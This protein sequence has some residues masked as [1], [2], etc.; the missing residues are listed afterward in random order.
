MKRRLFAVAFPALALAL[1][2]CNA[3]QSRQTK[4]YQPGE[5]AVVD[6]LTYS[7]V[8]TQI[9][10]RLGEDPNPRIPQNRFFVV[11][12]SVSNSGNK[13]LP[14]PSMTLVDDSGKVYNELADGTGVPRWLGVVRSVD[15]AQT[16][17]GAV[18]FDAPAAHYKVR[19][20]DDTDKDEIYVDL[21][22]NFMHEQMNSAPVASPD[23]VVKP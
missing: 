12:I 22:L 10:P 17:Q 15:A 21:P 4:V 6:K 8:D 23:D 13:S 20:T 7:I 9:S 2:G 3:S 11:Q 5:K 19:L 14:I 18:L 1:A 16:E